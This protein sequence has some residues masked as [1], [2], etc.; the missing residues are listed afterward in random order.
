MQQRIDFYR[1]TPWGTKAMAGLEQYLQGCGLEAGLIDL[2][3]LRASQLNG[4]GFCIDMHWQEARGHGESEQR[5]YGLDAWR[6]SPY[7]SERERAALMWTEAVTRVADG[8]VEDAVYEAVRPH[9]TEKELA[10][11]TWAVATINGWNRVAIALRSVPGSYRRPAETPGVPGV[12]AV[13]AAAFR[14]MQTRKPILVL[15]NAWDVASAVTFEAAGARALATTSAGVAAAL[16]YADGERL[17]RDLMIEAV[18][19]IAEA[20]KVPLTADMEAG[21]GRRPEQVAETARRLLAAG[22]IG[23]NL[24]DGTGDPQR[25]LRD[26]ADQVERIH[27]IREAAAAAGVPLVLNARVDVYIAQVGDPHGRLAETVRRAHAYREAGADSLFVPAVDD[28]ALIGTLVREIG[29]PLNILAGPGTP[30]I[31]ELETLGVARVSVGAY[32]MRASLTFARDAAR[33]LLQEGTYS[34]LGS[35]GMMTYRELN[36]LMPR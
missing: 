11:L 26:G 29:A 35:P 23:M 2:V 25:P 18:R 3:K 21:Y 19:R 1:V 22:A 13:K 24:E 32:L 36:E 5:L 27:A 8:H 10:D 34:R 31:A 4:C 17:P 15:P 6:E 30:S 14:A 28:P 33:E 7:Y 9:F 20:V 12:Q 16:G